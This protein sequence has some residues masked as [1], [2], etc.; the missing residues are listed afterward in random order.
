MIRAFIERVGRL[1][2]RKK[3]L[4]AGL[5]PDRLLTRQEARRVRQRLEKLE[6]KYGRS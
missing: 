6:R 2:F 4:D 1:W 3:M 5:D